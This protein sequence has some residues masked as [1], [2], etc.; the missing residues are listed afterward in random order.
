MI[1]SKGRD[2]R[3]QNNYVCMSEAGLGRG[4][5]MNSLCGTQN[6]PLWSFP[7]SSAHADQSG[8]RNDA[9]PYDK[10]FPERWLVWLF[11]RSTE[12]TGI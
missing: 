9:Q 7:A 8:L 3:K 4:G 2:L 6:S 10:V 11:F 12:L 1:Q 5:Q